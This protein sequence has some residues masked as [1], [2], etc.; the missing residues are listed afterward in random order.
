MMI[1]TLLERRAEIGLLKSLGATDVEVAILLFLEAGVMA[2]AGGAAGYLLGS[3]LA[4]RLA[5]TVFGV[6]VGIHLVLLPG[7]LGLALVVTLAG[8][9][10][11]LGRALKVSPA[12][13]LRG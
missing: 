2:L 10:L 5:L 12:V 13:A 6:P 8:S 7:C 3:A 9:A 4:W 1:A 11:P